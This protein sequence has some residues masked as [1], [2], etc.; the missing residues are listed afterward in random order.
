MRGFSLDGSSGS[1]S[2]ADAIEVQEGGTRNAQAA[3]LYSW[4]LGRELSGEMLI[5]NIGRCPGRYPVL[6]LRSSKNQSVQC[7][8]CRGATSVR[9]F[10][11]VT[12]TC[13]DNRGE[14]ADLNVE[15]DEE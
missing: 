10:W 3:L 8:Y 9:L 5:T 14:I 7:F 11:V 15:Q 12:E 6:L 2:L 4:E 13:I 1:C